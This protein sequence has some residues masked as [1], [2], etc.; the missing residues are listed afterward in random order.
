M[1]F[2]SPYGYFSNDGKNISFTT[3]ITPR[4]WGN[5]ISNGDYGMM[6]SQTGSGTVGGE[7]PGKTGSPVPSR[8]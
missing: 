5:V 2:K 6:I 1:K 7:M 8:T 3:P 4:P